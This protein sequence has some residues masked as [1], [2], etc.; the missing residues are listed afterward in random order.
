MVTVA[1]AEQ[2]MYRIRQKRHLC[3]Q[4][5]YF[6]KSKKIQTALVNYVALQ[7]DNPSSI[8]NALLFT[9]WRVRGLAWAASLLQ[10]LPQRR[11]LHP[12]WS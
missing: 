9:S 6:R 7:E 11:P 5:S 10:V 12:L 2:C 8:T 3:L 4:S 1:L